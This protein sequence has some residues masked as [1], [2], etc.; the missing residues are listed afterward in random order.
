MGDLRVIKTLPDREAEDRQA[1][2][3]EVLATITARAEAGELTGVY[4]V[5]EE[6]DGTVCTAWTRG[7]PVARI[8]RLALLQAELVA[9]EL[10]ED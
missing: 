9:H 7:D 4:L 8:G 10:E 6:R 3:L 2:I 1:E 5:V